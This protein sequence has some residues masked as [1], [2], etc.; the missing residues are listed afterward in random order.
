MQSAC[1]VLYCSL[2]SAVSTK[3]FP[4]YLINGTIFGGGGGEIYIYIYI[5]LYIYIGYI[6]KSFSL[7]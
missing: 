3:M 5:L 6:L 2:W 4:H 7:T 1:V